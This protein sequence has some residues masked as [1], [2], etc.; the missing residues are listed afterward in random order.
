MLHVR[1]SVGGL[2]MGEGALTTPNAKKM[3]ILELFTI[4]NWREVLEMKNLYERRPYQFEMFIS[5]DSNL[6]FA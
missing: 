3:V 6:C 1:N 4:P 5:C 2:G